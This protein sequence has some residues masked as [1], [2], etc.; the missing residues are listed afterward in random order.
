MLPTWPNDTPFRRKDCRESIYCRFRVKKVQLKYFKDFR[1]ENGSSQGHHL[2]LIGF[3][4][5]RLAQLTHNW[6]AGPNRAST[7]GMPPGPK[8][9][10]NATV[11]GRD[12]YKLLDALVLTLDVTV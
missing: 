2:A 12:W 9:L 6:T 7:P 1:T 10:E 4:W 3:C 11:H 5:A 8:S